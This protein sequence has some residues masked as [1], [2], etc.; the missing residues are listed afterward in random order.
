MFA[1]RFSAYDVRLALRT[2][3]L[4]ILATSVVWLIAFVT[5]ER[6]VATPGTGGRSIGVLPLVPIAAAI[7]VAIT[8]APARTAGELRALSAL[9]VSPLRARLS[10]IAAAGFLS[11][12]AAIGLFSPKIDV[13]PLFPPPAIASDMRVVKAPSGA[14]AFVSDRDGIIFGDD[15]VLGLLAISPSAPGPMGTPERARAAAA[16]TVALAGLAL[17]LWIAS[18][19]RRRPMRTLLTAAIYGGAQ[20]AAFQSAGAH[21]IPAL[22]T[23]LPALVLLVVA[24]LEHRTAA[25]LA[26]EEAWM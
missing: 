25:S 12:A 1:V 24:L 3:G 13:S 18:P 2:L 20:I 4:S 21:A 23:A 16:L 7:A 15:G 26:R 6:G 5:D 8:L 17:S 11:L 22:A 9:G 19:L 14:V 10:P